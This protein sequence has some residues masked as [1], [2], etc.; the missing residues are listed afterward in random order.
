M[1][2]LL[3]IED[4]EVDR[5]AFERFVAREKLPYD[6][7]PVGSVSEGKSAFKCDTF[8]VVVADYL[9]GDGTALDLLETIQAD[10]PF[11]VLTGK[12]DEQIA[13]QAM[14]AGASDYLIKDL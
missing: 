5:K 4:D 8:D 6:Y 11:I 1:I 12:G 13:V 10:V 9:L 14:K 2:K 7:V 3:Y